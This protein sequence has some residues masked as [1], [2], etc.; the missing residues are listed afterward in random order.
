MVRTQTVLSS[1]WVY[2]PELEAEA[3]RTAGARNVIPVP[4]E[5]HGIT[6]TRNWILRHAKDRHVVMIDDDVRSCGWL[7]LLGRASMKKPL[8][9]GG[10][11]GGIPEDL[12]GDRECGLS[13]LG[14]VDRRR[15]AH[16]L[17]LLSVSL[18][19]LRDGVLHWHH[20]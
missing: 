5:I 8:D 3:Y 6:R 18:A 7:K 17:P 14:C 2:V 20:Q 1:C 12:R 15:A 16:L 9:E 10:W 11:L 19:Q 4:D 13:D